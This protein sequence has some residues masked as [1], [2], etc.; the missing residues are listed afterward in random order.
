MGVE[1]YAQHVQNFTKCANKFPNRSFLIYNSFNMDGKLPFYQRAWFYVLSWTLVALVFYIWQISRMGGFQVNLVTMVLDFGLFVIGLVFWLVF[2][3]QFVLP[4]NKIGDRVK[5]LSRLLLH[6]SRG[7]GPAILVENGKTEADEEEKS[8]KGP[9]VIWLDSASAAQLR[10]S[11]KFTRTIGPGVYFTD[12][13]ETLAGIVDLHIQTQRIGPEDNDN[14]F[15]PKPENMSL[16][17]YDAIQQHAA[18]TRALTRDG[19][20]VVAKISTTFKIDADPVVG[21]GPGSRFGYFEPKKDEEN[22]HPVFK[23]IANEGVNPEKSLSAKELK[24]VAWN[25]FP[26]FVAVDLW[27]EYLSKFTLLELFTLIQQNP[28][29]SPSSSQLEIPKAAPRNDLGKTGTRR[30]IWQRGSDQILQQTNKFLTKWV[31]RLEKPPKAKNEPDKSKTPAG[32]KDETRIITALNIINDMMKERMTQPLVNEMD[33]NGKFTGRKI[34]SQEYKWLKDH[35]LRVFSA[36]VSGLKFPQK[37][38]EGLVNRWDSTW[39][40]NAKVQ[41]EVTEQ[42]RKVT[43]LRGREQG[44]YDYLLDLSHN[45]LKGESASHKDASSDS[46]ETLKKLLLHS[47]S[48]LI[49]SDRLERSLGT[50]IDELSEIIR[51]LESTGP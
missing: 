24:H 23:A 46:G 35:G 6:I 36:S 38:E 27:R 26:A 32:I 37:V 20:D 34:E 33:E 19:I 12:R 3:S 43:E 31:D 44:S 29:G 47:R 25:Q 10:T 41:R 40:H 5:I 45:L 39:E 48:T 49:R 51:W 17:Q 30:S 21:D 14:P 16:E 13:G 28:P 4:V 8:R 18:E 15:E 1:F 22:Q 7:H 9:G 42:Q 11:T 50:E 2:F